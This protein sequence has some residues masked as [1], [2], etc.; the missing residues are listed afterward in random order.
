MSPLVDELTGLGHV[1]V[2]QT[3]QYLL[4]S[5]G[6]IDKIDLKEN[7]VKMMGPYDPAVT[8]A[9]LIVHLEKGR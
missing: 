8:L 4:N 3:L 5:Y 6:A 9:R 7:A 1:N 2:L